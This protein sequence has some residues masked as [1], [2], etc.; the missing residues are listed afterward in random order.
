MDD[1][2][3]PLRIRDHLPLRDEDLRRVLAR[4]RA[5]QKP[6]LEGEPEESGEPDEGTGEAEDPR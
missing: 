5:G 2:I 3:D 4:M 1:P 6:L